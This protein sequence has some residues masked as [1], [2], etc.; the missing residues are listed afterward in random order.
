MKYQSLYSLTANINWQICFFMFLCLYQSV[1]VWTA[2]SL[3]SSCKLYPAMVFP[4]TVI[5]A[6]LND[7]WKSIRAS[8][9]AYRDVLVKRNVSIWK[10][11]WLFFLLHLWVFLSIW[12]RIYNNEVEFGIDNISDRM[13]LAVYS[14][15]CMDFVTGSWRTAR[16][17]DC[18][19]GG[20]VCSQ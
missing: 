19:S 11:N 4:V 12:Y 13:E 6:S 8:R 3:E 1:S 18:V 15:L 20:L 17:L 16:W 9:K 5:S 14:T 10:T 7:Q 2:I